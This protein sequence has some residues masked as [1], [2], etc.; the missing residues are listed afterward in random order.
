MPQNTAKHTGKSNRL[1][2]E[3]SPYLRQHAGNPVDWHAWGADAFAQAEKHNKPILL[4]IGYAACHWCH[5]MAHESF[6]D[7]KTAAVMNDLFINIKLDREERPDLDTIYQRALS[8]MGQ[9]GGWPLTM[10]LTPQG[11]PFWGGTYFPP[12]TRHGRVGFT[13]AMRQIDKIYRESPDKVSRTVDE[14]SRALHE[15]L[16]PPDDVFDVTL[17]LVDQ[18]C[19]RLQKSFDPVYGGFGD[20]PKFPQIPALHLLWRGFLRTGDAGLEKTVVTTLD[21]ICQGGIYDHIGGGIARY[22]VDQKWLVPHFEKMLYDNAQFIEILALVY[23]KTKNRLYRARAEQTIDWLHR[24]MRVF[25]AARG[26]AFASS[27]DADSE[28]AEGKYYIWDA[29]ELRE[30]LGSEYEFFQSYYG[31]SDDG[32]WEGHNIL[33]RLSAMAWAGDETESRLQQCLLKLAAK[34]GLRVKPGF[35][36]KILADWNGLLI[37]AFCIAGKVFAKPEWIESAK[38]AMRFVAKHLLAADTLW[39]CFA[40]GKAMHRANLDD[41]AN[42]IRAALMLHEASGEHEWFKIADSLL[43]HLQRDYWDEEL[44]G[45]FATHRDATDVICRVKSA[46]DHA[47]PAGNA[48]MIECL[49][50]YYYATGDLRA[51]ERAETIVTIFS[52]EV[53]RNF[54]PLATYLCG[55]EFCLRA[56]LHCIIGADAKPWADEIWQAP[57]P[58]KVILAIADKAAAFQPTHPAFGKTALHGKTTLYVCDGSRCLPPVTDRA[59]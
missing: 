52:G 23:C 58:H 57:N 53:T 49:M 39:H 47:T 5:V 7:P 40:D 15:T 55:Y 20:A 59:G 28:G 25:D 4:S 10:F 34:R 35:D 21:H 43:G 37:A 26:F 9:Q 8:L 1:A 31:T 42:L 44:G 17:S 19:A 51:R 41:Y 36:H 50:R 12:E 30:I 29:V 18:I 13:A 46:A 16:N 11:E 33:N 24:E 38:T 48:T 2:A 54:F 3:S 32:N 27:Y 45:Y 14:L 6:E 56:Q 22:T